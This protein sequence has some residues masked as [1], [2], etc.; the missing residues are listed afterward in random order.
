MHAVNNVYVSLQMG[1]NLKLTWDEPS[2]S[3]R[4]SV[5]YYLVEVN[6]MELN[7]TSPRADF[8]IIYN[9]SININI[10]YSSCWELSLST[11]FNLSLLEGKGILFFTSTVPL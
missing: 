6:Q 11:K 8:D 1:E 7:V 3:G 5:D 2:F 10:R 4:P 9:K